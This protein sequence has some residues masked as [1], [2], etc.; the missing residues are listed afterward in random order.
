MKFKFE[1][2][3]HDEEGLQSLLLFLRGRCPGVEEGKATAIPTAK[4][5]QTAAC[6]DGST[7][8]NTHQKMNKNN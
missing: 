2:M 4:M 6:G 8:I 7:K 1:F 3:P 5:K